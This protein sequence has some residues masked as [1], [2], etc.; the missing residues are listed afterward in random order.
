MMVTSPRSIN[1]R[2]AF[3]EIRFKGSMYCSSCVMKGQP[4]LDPRPVDESIQRPPRIVKPPA[5]SS[6]PGGQD[7]LGA[8]LRVRPFAERPHDA[9]HG[10]HVLLAVTCLRR[11]G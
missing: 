4:L 2:A 1:W 6:A 7:S 10:G 9:V 3:P 5:S 11:A 8:S